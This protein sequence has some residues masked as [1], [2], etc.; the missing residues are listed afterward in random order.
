MFNYKNLSDYEFEKLCCDIM[1]KKL[2]V[3]L[4]TFAK[5]KDGGIDATE[6]GRAHV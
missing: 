6:I 1:S 3:Q 2:G 5:G 4:R